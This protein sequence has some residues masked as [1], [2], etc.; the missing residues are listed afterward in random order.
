MTVTELSSPASPVLEYTHFYGPAHYT[1]AAVACRLWGGS[2]ATPSNATENALAVAAAGHNPI[3]CLWQNVYGGPSCGYTDAWIGV[4]DMGREVHKT[5]V[6]L[7]PTLS[8]L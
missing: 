7:P 6:A 3:H 1:D 2:L 8:P 4:N 5:R